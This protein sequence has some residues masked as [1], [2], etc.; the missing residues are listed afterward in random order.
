MDFDGNEWHF[1]QSKMVIYPLVICYDLPIE[2]L[3]FQ[4]AMLVITS[5]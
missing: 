4:F 1:Y 5:E 3:V 2:H